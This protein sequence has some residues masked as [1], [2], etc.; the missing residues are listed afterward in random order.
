MLTLVV[1][2]IVAGGTG[3]WAIRSYT[4][5]QTE[6]PI[7]DSIRAF[8]LASD[9]ADAKKLA[10]MMC[11]EEAS[12]FV[13]GFEASDDPP[14]PVENI[15]PRPVNIGTI[16]ITGDTATVDVTRPPS[17]TMTFKMKRVDGEWKL[18]NPD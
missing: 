14:I 15:R 18:C 12:Q 5:K 8:A 17:P 11:E 10:S 7:R 16:T 3:Y 6:A 9:T 13:D 2:L 1:V 4:T